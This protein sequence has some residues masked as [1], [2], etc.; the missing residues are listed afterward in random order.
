MPS[1]PVELPPPMV[2]QRM[3]GKT[4]VRELGGERWSSALQE[5][6]WE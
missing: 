5:E 2:A 3:T 4:K 1:P 6:G